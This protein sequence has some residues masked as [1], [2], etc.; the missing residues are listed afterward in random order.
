MK[1]KINKKNTLF[2]ILVFYFLVAYFNRSFVGIMIF[3][4]RLGE[5]IVLFGLLLSLFFFIS[6]NIGFKNNKILLFYRLIILSFLIS[7]FLN[8]GSFVSYTYKSSSYI[9]MV[10]YIFLGKYFSKHKLIP[11]S[12]YL[13]LG[14]LPLFSY[15]FSTGNYPNFIIDF[16]INF[17]INFNL[18]KQVTLFILY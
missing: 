7:L 15:I 16:S 3:G 4:F 8:N 14:L 10:S 6:G 1:I 5:F 13:V 2:T 11:S 17:L 18:Q 12:S 9:W